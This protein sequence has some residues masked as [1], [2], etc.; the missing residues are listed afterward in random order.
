MKKIRIHLSQPFEEILTA[1]L[2][3]PRA[4]HGSA[5]TSTSHEDQELKH[6][7]RGLYEA[8]HGRQVQTTVGLVPIAPPVASFLKHAPFYVATQLDFLVEAM[9]RV[10]TCPSAL[11][12]SGDESEAIGSGDREASPVPR[13]AAVDEQEIC[14]RATPAIRRVHLP[15]QGVSHG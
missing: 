2:S 6:V 3:L 15:A 13:N 12:R 1:L 5:P 8:A 14:S 9:A 10:I 7:L 11:A 4:A